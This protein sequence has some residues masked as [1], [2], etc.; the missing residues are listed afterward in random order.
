MIG[1]P[2]SHTLVKSVQ[3]PN[4]ISLAYREE[5]EGGE[6]LVFV[7]GMGSSRKAWNK[8]LPELSE[9]FRCLAIDLPNN[10][11]SEKGAYSFT[12]EFLSQV[13]LEFIGAMELEDPVLVGHSLGGQVILRTLIN[14][15]DRFSQAILVAPAGLETF[16]D[17]EIAWLR[18]NY[19]PEN[20]AK[21]S[22]EQIRRNEEVNFY[23]FPEDAE[24][25]VEDKL[26]LRGQAHF[27]LYCEMIPKSVVGMVTDKVN[28][29]LGEIQSRVLVLYGKED[30]LIPHP[31]LHTHEKT[32]KMAIRE[33]LKI[34]GV[35]LVLLDECGHF[36]QWEKAGRFNEEVKKFLGST[37]Y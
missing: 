20:M 24:F 36:L 22:E 16:S 30:A 29:Q 9:N 13:L 34:N 14:H 8:N 28:P 23:R 31:V 25:M 37:P 32:Q 6:T 7:H 35:Q 2:K 18:K 11:A 15:P 3:L 1:D 26:A 19:T 12:M 5:G 21:L 27:S 4:G 10:G 17:R 33:A